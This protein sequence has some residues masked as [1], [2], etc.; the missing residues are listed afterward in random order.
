MLQQKEEDFINF[1]KESNLSENRIATLKGIYKKLSL[2]EKINNKNVELSTKE[3][4]INLCQKDSTKIAN[5]SYGS[6]RTRVDSINVILDWLNIK[7]RL[8]VRDFDTD[9]VLKDS[10]IRYYTKE[11]IRKI[12]DLLINPQDRF[13]IYGLFCGIY[14]KE[15]SELLMLQDKDIDLEN[16]KIYL[17]SGK[18]IEIDDYLYDIL[19]DT[20]DKTYGSVYYMYIIS[21][22][23]S[24]AYTEYDLNMDSPYIIK[25]KPSQKNNNGLAP[26]SPS[27]IQRRLRRLAQAINIGQVEDKPKFNFGGTDLF[28]S[29][30]MSEMNELEKKEGIVWTVKKIKE[31]TKER[32]LGV[33]AFEIYRIYNR[34]YKRKSEE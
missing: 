16:R 9:K 19:L 31:W 22:F 26:M 33:Q 28:R 12:C 1:M 3:E 24:G 13:I 11:E 23:D 7:F 20:L 21:L 8:S 18:I 30:L 17:Q 10:K 2:W 34:K 29:G 6:F 32:D 25:M 15:Y 27:G 5:R 14:G 4:L